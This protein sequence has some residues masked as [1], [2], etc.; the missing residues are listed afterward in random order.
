VTADVSPFALTPP[1]AGGFAPAATSP[2][3]GEV[4]ATKQRE[5]VAARFASSPYFPA[6][7]IGLAPSFTSRKHSSHSA[8][9]SFRDSPWKSF[10]AS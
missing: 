9:S 6:S 5:S 3:R 4:K 10:A 7:V 8:S 1:A 2:S